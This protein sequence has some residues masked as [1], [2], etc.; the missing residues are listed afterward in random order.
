MYS[1]LWCITGTAT[2]ICFYILQDKLAFCR[3]LLKKQFLVKIIRRQDPHKIYFDLILLLK[4]WWHL[5]IIILCWLDYIS[6]KKVISTL[7][8]I[9]ILPDTRFYS[10]NQHSRYCLILNSNQLSQT[11]SNLYFAWSYCFISYNNM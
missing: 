8:L 2:E 7:E 4:S 10:L 5:S 9:I 6:A 3:K 11:K 1:S